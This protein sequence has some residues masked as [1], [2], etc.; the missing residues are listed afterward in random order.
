MGDLNR[1][2]RIHP[3]LHHLDFDPQGFEWI[4]C[5]NHN[6]SILAYLRKSENESLIIVFNFTPVIRKDYRIGVPLSGQYEEIFNSDSRYYEGTN[7]GNSNPIYTD[8]MPRMS[9]PYSISL[10]LPPLAGIII[11]HTK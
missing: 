2:Y 8:D 6:Q 11:K 1:L 4:D 5:E 3:A 7:L 10:T 9:R